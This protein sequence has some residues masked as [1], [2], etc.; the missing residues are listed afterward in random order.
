MH[1]KNVAYIGK[2]RCIAACIAL[3]CMCALP[4]CE[5][6]YRVV[7][8]GWDDFPQD[9]KPSQTESSNSALA[10]SGDREWAIALH[11]FTGP[12]REKQAQ[13]TLERLQNETNLT[14]LWVESSPTTATVYR[15]RFDDP[16]AGDAQTALQQTR[17]TTL[18][19]QRPFA[20]ARFV[21]LGDGGTQN[22]NDPLNL[23]RHS[24]QYTLQVGFYTSEFDGDRQT[25][26]E[27]AAKTLREAGHKAF[28]YHGDN[29]SLVTVGVF[30]YQQAFVT[31]N[32][33][34]APS[35]TIDT[36]AP[37]IREIQE[38]FPYNLKDA[39]QLRQAQQGEH[40]DAQESGIVRVF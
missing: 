39:R 33:P 24:G 13:T 19:G 18:Q 28:Y 36:Y 29:Q 27:R 40:P 25:A 32:D 8:S 7:D 31:K 2:R 3:L 35:A 21:Q 14:G 6:E 20:R 11:R 26:A 5:M 15:G 9:P 17:Q 4:G 38:T 34:R 1:T 16:Q 30:T 10:A 22:L 23:K 37:Q 12:E